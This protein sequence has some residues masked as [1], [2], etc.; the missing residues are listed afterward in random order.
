MKKLHQTELNQRRKVKR[1]SNLFEEIIEEVEE[2]PLYPTL[3]GL[4]LVKYANFLAKTNQDYGASGNAYARKAI[5]I[6]DANPVILRGVARFY[7]LTAG[8]SIFKKYNKLE[9]AKQIL[10]NILRTN[11]TAVK[12]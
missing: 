5:K 2:S 11:R 8:E 3:H 6:A 10:E 9:Q 1:I 12:N 4:A 7:V